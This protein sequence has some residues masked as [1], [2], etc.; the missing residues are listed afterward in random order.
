MK[1][2]GK[3]KIFENLHEIVDPNHTALLVWDVVEVLIKNAVNKDQFINNL[4]LF[5]AAARKSNISI[6]YAKTILLPADLQ[7]SWR[8]Y[9][10]MR[11]SGV[12][13]PANLP[14]WLKPGSKPSEIVAEIGPQPED[15]VINKHTASIFIG[16][17]FEYMMRNRG[18]NT[19]LFTGYS[20]EVGVD[21]SARDSSNRGFYTVVVED[22][23]ASS[24][25]KAHDSILDVLRHLCIVTNSTNIIKEWQ[26]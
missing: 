26:S 22:C 25:K 21:S 11:D 12:T 3:N 14:D 5:I 1:T 7:S 18:I 9:T 10:F 20:T 2:L 16:T 17:H 8:L 24:N 15:I 6:F 4:K 23:V 13:D 19:I